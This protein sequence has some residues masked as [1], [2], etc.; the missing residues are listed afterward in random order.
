MA[1]KPAEVY[2]SGGVDSRSNPI[3]MPPDR[4]L[5]VH[6]FWPQQDGSYRLRDGYTLLANGLQPGV[7]IHSM[8]STNVNIANIVPSYS[9]A[10]INVTLGRFFVT[11][12]GPK[13]SAAQIAQL[14][15]YGV[16]FVGV[17]TATWLN[18]FPLAVLG[19]FAG[20][21]PYTT[22]GFTNSPTGMPFNYGP[23]TDTGATVS[24]TLGPPTRQEVIVFWQG[25]TPYLLNQQTGIVITPIIKGTAIQSSSRFCYFYTNGHLHAFNG[26]DAKWFDGT[27]WRDIGLPT[28]TAAQAAAIQFVIGDASITTAQA[29]SVGLTATGGG[30]WSGSDSVKVF[31]AFFD[32]ATN[33]LATS[34]TALGSGPVTMAA[35]NEISVTG[36]PV[37]PISTVVGLLGFQS[38]AAPG[39]IFAI[40][41]TGG[42]LANRINNVTV[43]GN[44]VTINLLG[45]GLATGAVIT[46][47]Q[48]F[49]SAPSFGPFAV[50]VIDAN[51]FSFQSN[52]ASLYTAAQ[53][54][55]GAV[56]KLIV[57]PHGTTTGTIDQSGALAQG[58]IFNTAG[59][60]LLPYMNDPTQISGLPA[61][62]VGGAQ[63]GYQFYASIYN[64]VTGHVGNRTPLGFRF[65]NIS[66]AASILF[67]NCPIFTD[68]EWVLLLGR[69][70]DG[71]EIPYAITDQY[72]NWQY[73]PNNQATFTLFPYSIDG[74]SELPSRNYPPPGT[75]D[76]NYQYS[77]LPGGALQNPPINGTFTSAWVE[78]DHC[79]GVLAG[80]PTIYRSGS[81]LDMREGQFVGLPEQ[82]WDPADIETFPTGNPVVAGHGYQQESWC[83]SKEDCGI[84]MELNG[85][86]SWQGPYNVGAAGQHAW[87]RGWQNLPFW[88]TGEKQLATVSLGGW[89]QLAGM[90]ST[91]NAGPILISGEYEAALLAQIGDAYLSQTEVCYIRKPLEMIEVLRIKC[92]DVNG[93]P[94]TIIHDFNLRDEKSPYGQ[95]YQE[96]FAGSLVAPLLFPIT[97]T[98]ANGQLTIILPTWT[99]LPIVIG[100]AYFL[101]NMTNPA[102]NG[103][104]TLIEA[105]YVRLGLSLTLQLT[106]TQAGPD[107]T[108]PAAG[109]IAVSGFTQEAIRDVNQKPQVVAGGSDGNLYQL[110]SGGNDNGTEFTAQALRLVNMGPQR[111]AAKFLEWYGD[112]NAQWYITRK[113]NSAF[114][115]M[116]MDNLTQESPEEVQGQDGD[117]RWSVAIPHPEMVHAYILLQLTSHSADGTTALSVPP[118]MPVEMYGRVWLV[119]PQLG[120]AR[121]R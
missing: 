87:A 49:T 85:A 86:T 9:I 43:V 68:S 117:S 109:D 63:P 15:S 47:D 10:S 12:A 106:C 14:V 99:G 46:L 40:P 81:A 89:Q 107:V 51:N 25:T 114:N 44:T 62:S 108:T 78:S 97:A 90:T 45:H 36:L 60:N 74:S 94:F 116:Q 20:E 4:C 3:V 65:D 105:V 118:H 31:F 66:S 53:L 71:A 34:A 38:A 59:Q 112:R 22:L 67:S 95:A 17:T 27:Y 58:V 30:H 64:L 57:I 120:A 5:V 52:Q 69:T 77:L 100:N 28:L 19:D 33:I 82:S 70:G 104:A 39:A 42:V 72:G 79:C 11:L 24:Q 96:N 110:Y 84:L 29:G 50:T 61:S 101:I 48:S 92:F 119:S 41:Y 83:F 75:L 21:E 88:V 111:T 121:P 26:T 102:L 18:N 73:V 91:A 54:Q 13:L 35:G 56:C 93:N 55:G 23:A 103:S 80:S 76:C 115:V 2:P 98:R 6:D 7:P 8:V 1:L 16:T 113:L 32:T 37:S